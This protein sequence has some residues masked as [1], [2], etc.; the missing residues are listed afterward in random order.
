[1]RRRLMIIGAVVVALVAAWVVPIV[2]LNVVEN[3]RTVDIRQLVVNDPN[4]YPALS[5]LPWTSPSTSPVSEATY[6]RT[7]MSGDVLLGET[8]HRYASALSAL[9]TFSTQDPL[10]TNARKHHTVMAQAPDGL[11]ADQ[12]ELICGGYKHTPG[13]HT[14]TCSSWAARMRYGQYIVD[15]TIVN[16]VLAS[17]KFLPIARHI[18]AVAARALRPGNAS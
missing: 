10:L 7:W 6:Q 11:F 4:T 5:R 14:G 1:M 15:V 2:A 9:Y 16:H 13:T 12:A 8:V 17:S 18:D 3:R